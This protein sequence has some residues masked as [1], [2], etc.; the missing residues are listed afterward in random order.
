MRIFEIIFSPTGG[1]QKCAD[2]FVAAFGKE[3][4][5]IDLADFSYDFAATDITSEDVCIIAA[6]AFGGRIP[7]VA[8]NRLKLIKG[9]GAK[10]I[11]IAVYG[12]REF[13]DCLVELQ[14]IASDIEELNTFASRIIEMFTEKLS[15]VATERKQ[16]SLYL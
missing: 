3:V 4:E 8:V 13:D 2:I 6:P 16:N 9:N 1:T 10:A 7:E 15:A 14:D 5:L 11:L 12:N